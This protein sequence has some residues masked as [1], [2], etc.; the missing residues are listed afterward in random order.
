MLFLLGGI[1][2]LLGYITLLP[3]LVG[4]IYNEYYCSII[5]II[6]GIFTIF[7]GKILKKFKTKKKITLKNAMIVSALSWLIASLIGGIPFYL[8]LHNFG[9]IDGVYESM[10]AW[11][12]TGMTLISNV[13]VVPKTILFWRS[14]E[15]WIGGVGI[16]VFFSL[17]AGNLANILYVSEARQEKI[18]PSSINTVKAIVK[19]YVLYTVVGILLLFFSGLSLFDA[20][21][22][23]FTGI[24]T[25]GMSVSNYSF[26]Y[27]D[28]AKI[29]MIFIMLV[30]GVISFNVHYKLLTGKCCNDLQL[31]YAMIVIFIVS[32]IIY[33]HDHVD[34][35]DSL[36]LVTSA[37][38]ST[39]FTTFNISTLSNFSLYLLVFVMLIG[40]TTNTTTGG[41][42]IIRFL[43]ILKTV[44]YEIKKHF[45]P[46]SAVFYE[47]LGNEELKIESIREAFTMFIL[48]LGTSFIISLYLIYAGINPLCAIFDGVSFVSNIGLSLGAVNLNSPIL[49][50]ILGI[51]GMW[52]GRL[53]FFPVLILVVELI[54]IIYKKL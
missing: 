52:A 29:V 20:I 14:L 32:L 53:E 25:G 7:L 31:K 22:L 30:G 40:G 50:K 19:I 42:K 41:V 28:L 3:S 4:I 16:L 12:T 43:V 37:L 17:I 27:N 35:L 5:F 15:Q 26:P 21:N 47:K 9:Y 45:Y 24:S 44:Y 11:T 48:Y 6:L 2:E 8:L 46:K 18:L 54:R 36:F 13:N 38:T 10:S 51:F 39:G 23:T 1:L 33:F 49:A 34:F